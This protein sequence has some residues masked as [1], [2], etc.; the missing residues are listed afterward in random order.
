VYRRL[1]GSRDEDIRAVLRS[2]KKRV[3]RSRDVLEKL[4]RITGEMQYGDIS[5]FRRAIS[6]WTYDQD[7]GRQEVEGALSMFEELHVGIQT[8]LI[9]A[10]MYVLDG[11]LPTMKPS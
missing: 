6:Y 1:R 3:K 2:L 8:H 5:V 4:T 11:F 10:S 9:T 7:G